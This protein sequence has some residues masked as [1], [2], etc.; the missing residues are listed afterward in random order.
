M[1]KLAALLSVLVLSLF[2]AGPLSAQDQDKDKERQRR[3][4]PEGR[5]QAAPRENPRAE[6]RREP[7]QERAEPRRAGC[8]EERGRARSN[9][10]RRAGRRR[11]WSDASCARGGR[12]DGKRV[13]FSNVSQAR[14]WALE[15]GYG[16]IRGEFV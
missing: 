3:R 2:V 7:P 15:N 16:G 14:A 10:S 13:E 5:G 6:P 4:P 8:G 1:R 11:Y 9:H 12:H